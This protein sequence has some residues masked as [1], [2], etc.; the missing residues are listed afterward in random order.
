MREFIVC[1][2]LIPSLA[3]VLWMTAFETDRAKLYARMAEEPDADTLARADELM[4]RRLR[5]EPMAYLMGHREFY[6]LERL[7]GKAA[8]VVR[9]V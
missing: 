9:V 2:L 7:W 8:Q 4:E 1:V 3:C 6:G 5:H